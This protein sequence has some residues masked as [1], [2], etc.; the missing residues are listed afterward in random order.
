MFRY[1]DLAASVPSTEE[2]NEV[3]RDLV[4]KEV[5]VDAPADEALVMEELTDAFFS[6]QPSRMADSHSELLFCASCFG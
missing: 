6:K 5:F 1:P 3:A 2:S 4:E